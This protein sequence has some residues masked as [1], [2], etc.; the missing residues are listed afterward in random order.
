MK[1]SFFVSAALVAVSALLPAHAATQMWGKTP[2]VACRDSA[3][4]VSGHDV[5]RAT[6]RDGIANC[7]TALAGKL[8]AHD[9][10]A[11][12]ANRGVLEASMGMSGAAIGDFNEALS[13][14]PG[15]AN[16]YVNRGVAYLK[17]ARFEEARADFSHALDMNVA[18]QARVF[19]DRGVAEEKLGRVSDAYHDYRWAAN[20]DP[21]FKPAAVELARFSVSPRYASN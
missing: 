6:S 14:D 17:A 16:I 19:F 11:T 10:A 18:D 8:N 13:R 7:T 2:V 9:T 21:G 12:L 20:L 1:H 5:S 15:A 4:L 3:A